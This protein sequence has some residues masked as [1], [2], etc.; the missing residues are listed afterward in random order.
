MV[1]VGGVKNGFVSAEASAFSVGSDCSIL[2]IVVAASPVRGE[3]PC[4]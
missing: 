3:I 4:I 1:Y 2:R